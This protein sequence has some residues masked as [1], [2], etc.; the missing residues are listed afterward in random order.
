MQLNILAIL[1][2]LFF[3][4]FGTNGINQLELFPGLQCSYNYDLE[5][6]THR[7]KHSTTVI[8][9]SSYEM[10]KYMG[11]QLNLVHIKAVNCS[12]VICVS[13]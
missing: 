6:H 3:S 5:L 8:S 11:L 9:G 7:G 2:K 13:L 10:W 12:I 1:I 4:F